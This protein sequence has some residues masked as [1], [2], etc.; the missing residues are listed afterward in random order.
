MLNFD[1]QQPGSPIY[2]AENSFNYEHMLRHSFWK[3]I[4]ETGLI[5][6]DQLNEMEAVVLSK[7]VKKKGH[8]KIPALQGGIETE[9]NILRS[10]IDKIIVYLKKLQDSNQ[11]YQ[12]A[13]KE[14][15]NLRKANGLINV[16]RAGKTKHLSSSVMERNIR[17]I[18]L[19]PRTARLLESAGIN[20]LEQ[21]RKSSLSHLRNQ[22]RF[23]VKTIHDIETILLKYSTNK[24]GN[25]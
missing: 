18:G 7:L 20:T 19:S 21:L 23:G 2:I 6:I 12:V 25:Q 8:A 17:E 3:I 15:E 13:G 16:S 5:H 14:N 4:S 24:A 22:A 10:A 11:R 9:L 1:K